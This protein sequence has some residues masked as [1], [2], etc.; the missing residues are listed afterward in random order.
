MMVVLTRR[1]ICGSCWS[2]C[3]KNYVNHYP[4]A[5]IKIK[6]ILL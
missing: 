2:E 5:T 6:T 3:A 1:D 4:E